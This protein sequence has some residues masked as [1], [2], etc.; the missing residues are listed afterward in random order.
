MNFV[1]NGDSGD[2]PGLRGSRCAEC[3]EVVFPAVLDCPSCLATGSMVDHQLEGHGEIA[4]FTVAERGP[5]GFDVPYV[6]AWVRLDDGPTVFGILV[7]NDPSNAQLA[8]GQP[9]T[10]TI[11][12]IGSPASDV[13]GW[14]FVPD[15]V[16]K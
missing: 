5:T 15:A 9:V 2:R 1:I 7:V 4:N 3:G 6:Q 14:Q 16:T 10:I 11:G 8:H 12:P 13:M